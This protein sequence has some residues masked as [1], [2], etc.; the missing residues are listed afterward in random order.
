MTIPDPAHN[1][2]PTP[3][4]LHCIYTIKTTNFYFFFMDRP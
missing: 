4:F 1:P 3:N 2:D